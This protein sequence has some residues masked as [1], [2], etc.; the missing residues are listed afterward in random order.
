MG[1]YILLYS[2]QYIERILLYMYSILQYIAV[3]CTFKINTQ[4]EMYDIC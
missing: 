3:Y 2:V 1:D 4:R